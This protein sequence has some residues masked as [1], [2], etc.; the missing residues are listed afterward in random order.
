MTPELEQ[1]ILSSE[2]IRTHA[3]DHA[4]AHDLY[5][6]IALNK[7]TKNTFVPTRRNAVTDY[8]K[9]IA[10]AIV[11]NLRNTEDYAYWYNRN[12]TDH[13]TKEVERDLKKAGWLVVKS[14]AKKPQT[15]HDATTEHRPWWNFWQKHK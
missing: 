11:S 6:A 2:T 7:L 4:Y 1:S 15:S 10:A 5:S 9:R 13:M 12:P 8:S 3:Q 14:K